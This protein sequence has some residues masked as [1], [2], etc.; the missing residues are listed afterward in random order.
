MSKHYEAHVESAQSYFNEGNYQ[1]ARAASLRALES[2]APAN[3]NR[4]LCILGCSLLRLEEE[5]EGRE[6]LEQAMQVTDNPVVM[7][8]L[9]RIYTREKIFDDKCAQTIDKAIELAPDNGNAYV[10]RYELLS[11]KGCYAEALEDLKKG[12]RRGAEYPSHT[13]FEKVQNWAQ[14]LCDEGRFEDAFSL[15]NGVADFFNSVEFFLLNARLAELAQ[16]PRE[17]VQYYKKSLSFLRA[18]KLRT[19]VLECIARHAI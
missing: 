1:A 18:G 9:V 4:A 10:A 7:G 8:E 3:D 6:V 12:L 2:K 17:A 13:V 16:K 5:A 19:E 14:I 11:H 15:T